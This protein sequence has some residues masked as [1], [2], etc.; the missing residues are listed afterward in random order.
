MTALRRDLPAY[1]RLALMW[2]QLAYAY[3]FNILF[4]VLTTVVKIYLLRAVWT[5]VYAGRGSVAGVELESMIAYLTLANLQLWITYP[6]LAEMLQGRI[7][8]GRIAIDLARPVPLIGQLLA[9]QLGATAGLLPF[10]VLVLPLA[11]WFGNLALPSSPGAALLYLVSFALAYLV[12]TM[13]GLI[14][15]LLAFWLMETWALAIIYQFVNQFFAG[16]L[17]PLWL[18][19]PGL[20]LMA[21]LLPFQ[22]QAH[23]PLSIYMGQLAGADALRGLAIQAFWV[24]A[25]FGLAQLVWN[26]AMHKVVIQGG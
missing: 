9:Q 17:V 19:P 16:A 25:L 15:G 20:R 10:L 12:M 4:W 6:I 5:A 14:F 21:E 26:R 24:V 1:W 2:P 18:F 13:F 11:Y 22:T 8:E 7:R 23:I 3:R